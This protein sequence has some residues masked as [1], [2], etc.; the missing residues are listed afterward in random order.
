MKVGQIERRLSEASKLGFKKCIVP[1]SYS[2]ETKKRTDDIVTIECETILDAVR[3]ALNVS[4]PNNAEFSIRSSPPI[5][6][7]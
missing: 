6:L 5:K 7:E 2:K 4:L 1:P 3:V